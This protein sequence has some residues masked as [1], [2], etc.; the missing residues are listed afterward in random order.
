MLPCLSCGKDVAQPSRKQSKPKRYC[1]STCRNRVHR[2]KK[3]TELEP[4]QC[5][6]CPTTFVPERSIGT[7]QK[8]CSDACRL[9]FKWKVQAER[10]KAKRHLLRRA[11]GLQS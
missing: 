5:L 4:I 3:R 10:R 9:T 11:R 7:R 8:Y 6:A 1:N 2:E